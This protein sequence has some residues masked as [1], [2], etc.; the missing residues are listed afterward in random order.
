MAF[1]SPG[2]SAVPASMFDADG[3]LLPPTVLESEVMLL[4]CL[5][6]G[7]CQAA[8]VILFIQLTTTT[9]ST[10]A[11]PKPSRGKR[12]NSGNVK[13][14][15]VHG[16]KDNSVHGKGGQVV[17]SDGEKQQAKVLAAI[18]AIG[19]VLDQEPSLKNHDRDAKMLRSLLPALQRLTS[20]SSAGSRSSVGSSDRG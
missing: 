15:S 9:S 10:A 12:D 14:N 17:E 3:S 8:G 2:A 20:T 11:V 5:A 13:D 7:L 18:D 4:L 19:R 16:K 6:M 1:M